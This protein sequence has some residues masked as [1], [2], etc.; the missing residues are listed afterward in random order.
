MKSSENRAVLREA[1][2]VLLLTEDE[3]N[4]INGGSKSVS[5]GGKFTP[6]SNYPSQH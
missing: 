4:A 6:Y 1:A 5:S 2:P 3:L